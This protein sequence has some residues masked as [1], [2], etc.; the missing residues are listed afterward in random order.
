MEEHLVHRDILNLLPPELFRVDITF[1]TSP[2]SLVR[3]HCSR[4]VVH[5]R[6]LHDT[7]SL[8]LERLLRVTVDESVEERDQTVKRN[9]RGTGHLFRH[10]QLVCLKRNGRVEVG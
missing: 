6:R 5:S 10:Q 9:V 2:R 1:L 3:D 8:R 4:S 7:R